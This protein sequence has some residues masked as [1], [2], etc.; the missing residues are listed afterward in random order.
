[1]SLPQHPQGYGCCMNTYTIKILD[2]MIFYPQPPVFSLKG[3]SSRR[4]DG[5]CIEKVIRKEKLVG[6]IEGM[7]SALN[8]SFSKKVKKEIQDMLCL[9]R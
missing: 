6:E 2:F 5:K 3:V 7:Y 1:M 8:C 4:R 9:G